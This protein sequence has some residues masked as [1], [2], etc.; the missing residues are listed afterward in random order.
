MLLQYRVLPAV[1]ALVREKARF[2]AGSLRIEWA[3]QYPQVF[4][5]Q[6]ERIAANQAGGHFFEWFA[7]VHLYETTGWLSLVESYQFKIQKWK[8]NVL[9]KLGA[10]ELLEFFDS[11]GKAGF[12]RRQ[13]PDLLVYAPDLSEF[14]FC[15]VK[16]PKDRLRPVQIEYFR[17]MAKAAGGKEVV[18]LPV[19]LSI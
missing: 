17:A 16:G 10:S 7:A 12:G 13:A 9:Q 1:T 11:Q 2:H 15:E 19:E 6:E 14:Y 4:D 5:E 3:A 18:I 8:R